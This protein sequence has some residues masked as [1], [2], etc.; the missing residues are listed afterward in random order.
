MRDK[1]FHNN[2]GSIKTI[3]DYAEYLL[4]KFN[5]EIQSSHFGNGRS[6]SM[7]GSTVQFYPPAELENYE[8]G[9]V[10]IE[11]I[12]T[13][14]ESHSHFTDNSRQDASTTYEH[15]DRLIHQ[16]LDRK[17]RKHRCGNSIY[18][19]LLLSSVH[20]IVIDQA[21]GAPGHGKDIVDVINAIGKK[22]LAGKMCLIGTPEANNG[23]TMMQA[24]S[25]LENA[26]TSLAAESVRL[27]TEESRVRG[28]K[29]YAKHAKRE[30]NA[31]LKERH[32]NLHFDSKTSKC[33]RK[34]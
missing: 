13:V 20:G 6:L 9:L 18:I 33:E 12:N 3:R 7:E 16:L 24:A 17:V 4:V 1:A 25:M 22:Y 2:S 11:E 27:C 32:Y 29:G 30:A 28:V 23:P 15:I 10:R 21:T 31:P 26:S 34:D 14:L 8:K 5:L 19:N